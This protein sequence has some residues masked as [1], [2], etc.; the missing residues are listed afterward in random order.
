MLKQAVLKTFFNKR[1][2]H[3]MKNFRWTNMNATHN[4]N[5]IIILYYIIKIIYSFTKVGI[6]TRFKGC[7]I[8]TYLLC[9]SSTKKF[10][11]SKS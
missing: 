4:N 3:K 7:V 6:P 11:N 8:V 9:W 2:I 10:N 1:C 5:N